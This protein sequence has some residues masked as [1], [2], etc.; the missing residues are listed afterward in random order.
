[1]IIRGLL[2]NAEPEDTFA[3]LSAGTRT[4]SPM[5]ERQAVTPENV[6]QALGF[7]ENSHLIGALDL[8]QALTEAAA[9]LKDG[10]NPHLVH[11]GTGIAAMGE[12]RQ[13]KLLARLPDEVKYI[14]I[15]VGRR[16][17][18]ALMKAAAEKTGGLFTQINPDEPLSWRTFELASTL[19]TPRML[20][21]KV[22]D[23]AR[24][25]W[26]PMT[27]LLSQGEE[28][29]AVCRLE[30]R[31]L[32]ETVHVEGFVGDKLAAEALP[33]KDVMKEAGYIPRTWARLEIDRLL[34]EDA[35]KHKKEIVELSK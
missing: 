7:L 21:I 12:Q 15:G 17:N 34:A 6:E 2:Q 30:S 23:S 13:E 9:L 18:R 25:R 20:G 31:E 24:N 16:W 14:G 27:T 11:V 4:R 3:V 8:E 35:A 29:C 19:N 1:E 33:V 26:L 10:R 32:P 28:L 5:K 22:S